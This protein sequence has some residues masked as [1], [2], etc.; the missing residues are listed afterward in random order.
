MVAA[1]SALPGPSA[2]HP[3]QS[4]KHSLTIREGFVEDDFEIPVEPDDPT[5]R[6]V[7]WPEVSPLGDL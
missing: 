4:S 1:T 2:L 6:S 5:K 3:A 7:D